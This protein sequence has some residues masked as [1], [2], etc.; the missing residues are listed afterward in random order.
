MLR[1]NAGRILVLAALHFV[2]DFYAGLLRPLMQP[3]LIDHFRVG[4]G[5]IVALLGAAGILINLVQPVS[6]AIL[7][8]RGMPSLLIAGPLLALLIALIGLSGAW[9]VGVALLLVS[10]FGIGIVH[11]EGMMATHALSGSR[12]G[13]GVATYVTGGFLGHS[14]ASWFSAAWAVEHGLDGFWLFALPGLAVVVLV[15]LSGLHRL[16]GHVDA[17]AP[18]GVR[19][20]IPFWVVFIFSAAVATNMCVLGDFVTPLLVRRFGAQAQFWGGTVL[21]VFGLSGATGS[22][23]W[24]YAAEHWGK[25]RTLALTHALAAP[26]VLGLLHAS[27]GSAAALWAAPVGFLAGSAIPVVMVLGRAAPGVP[28]RMRTGML[29]GGSFTVGAATVVLVGQYVDAFAETD[30]APV[31]AG[32]TGVLCVTFGVVVF[33]TLASMRREPRG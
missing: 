33:G 9:G 23:V 13:L 1:T 31:L 2:V 20:R 7:P 32:M 27:S 25:C 17:P 29:M 11:P 8:R 16:H 15:F 6:A 19:H 12:Q 21:L 18:L 14:I 22:Y 3:T 30:P 5:E 10:A 4:F 24:Q 26:F 28:S